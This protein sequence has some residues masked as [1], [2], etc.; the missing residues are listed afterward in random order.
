VIRLAV[1]VRREHAELVLADLLELAPGGVEEAGD[2]DSVEYAVYGAP[3]EL[4]SLP[5]LQAAAGD[6]LMQVATREIPDDWAERWKR[7]HR[8]VVV[9]PP[10]AQPPGARAVPSLVVRPPW[11]PASAAAAVAAGHRAGAATAGHRVGAEAGAGRAAESRGAA[12][13]IR[14]TEQIVIDPGQAFGTGAHATTRQCLALLL[15]LTAGEGSRA[16]LVDLGTGSGVLAIAAARLG[17]A[18]VTAIDS[19]RESVEAASANAAANEVRVAV[20]RGDLRD[21]AVL[22]AA[23]CAAPPG[24]GPVVLAN[25]LHPLLCEL[26]EAMPICPAHLIAGGMTPG[27]AGQVSTTFASRLRM[28]ERGRARDGG[29]A[30]LWLSAA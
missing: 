18:P 8:P 3:G 27:Q 5:S 1:R 24:S 15:A 19:E 9:D 22:D 16:A 2:A 21:A 26:A 11:E 4:P 10:A 12:A 17:F 20:R 23:F 14:G 13:T 25:L 28:R 30:S 6:A 29:W 7:F